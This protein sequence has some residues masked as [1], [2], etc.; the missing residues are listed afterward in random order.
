M[1]SM[2]ALRLEDISGPPNGPDAVGADLATEVG[3][4][5][6]D[7][8]RDVPARPDELGETLL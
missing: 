3:D 7:H 4:V 1:A 5:D 2:R 8:V 6:L